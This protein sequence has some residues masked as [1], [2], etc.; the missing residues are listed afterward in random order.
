MFSLS[1]QTRGHLYKLYN[2]R[3]TKFVEIFFIDRV[4]NVWNMLPSAVNFISLS[5]F[6]SLLNSV[7]FSA[8]LKCTV[9]FHQ[10]RFTVTIY[11]YGLLSSVAVSDYLSP[12]SNMSM[13]SS[14]QSRSPPY[15]LMPPNFPFRYNT[16]SSQFR[17]R[18]RL[19]QA[20]LLRTAK[21]TLT[22]LTKLYM[23]QKINDN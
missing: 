9:H 18:F 11:S 12:R 6:E 15:T 10:M 3:S 2:S 5:T 19:Q 13:Q 20:C 22:S 23:K 14:L 21:H 7:D 1:S 4:V 17:F 16:P 8:Y